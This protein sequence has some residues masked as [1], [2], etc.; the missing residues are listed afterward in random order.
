MHG[1]EEVLPLL[2]L[3][4]GSGHVSGVR[5]CLEIIVTHV[6][7]RFDLRQ[8]LLQPRRHLC[9]DRLHRS[10]LVQMLRCQPSV[11][12]VRKDRVQEVVVVGRD[13][14]EPQF[15]DRFLLPLPFRFL[16]I[17]DLRPDFLVG[18]VDDT[19]DLFHLSLEHVVVLED[20]FFHVHPCL[21]EPVCK[22]PCF[23]KGLFGF[24]DI[25][26]GGF[27]AVDV[28]CNGICLLF[29]FFVR[30]EIDLRYFI[31]NIVLFFDNFQ[32]VQFV[33]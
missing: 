32:I 5:V 12:G 23:G 20:L 2:D 17:L 14:L 15:V 33:H 16:H 27:H 13:P 11:E 31:S 9:F 24:L 26:F 28:F 30:R 18:V 3:L 8:R 25:L 19:D 29:V 6:P 1:V 4:N 21:V 10:R 22:L 7:E